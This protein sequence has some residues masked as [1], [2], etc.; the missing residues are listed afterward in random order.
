MAATSAGALGGRIVL[1]AVL[2]TTLGGGRGDDGEEPVQDQH[3]LL[4]YKAL[5]LGSL[6]IKKE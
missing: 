2:P 3:R 4:S 1:T 5:I 6:N